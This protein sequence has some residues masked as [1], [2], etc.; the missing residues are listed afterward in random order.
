MKR[1]VTIEKLSDFEIEK[2]TFS[3][4]NEIEKIIQFI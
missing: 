3:L 4:F 2:V 1:E